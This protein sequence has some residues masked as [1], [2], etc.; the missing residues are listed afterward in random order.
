VVERYH[1][2]ALSIVWPAGAGTGFA[3]CGLCGV[4][5]GSADVSRQRYRVSSVD[6]AERQA[7][8]TVYRLRVRPHDKT[9][10]EYTLLVA[11]PAGRE[12]APHD[13]GQLLELDERLL[14][15]E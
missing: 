9:A 15:R 12:G 1:R 6:V 10:P 14:M 5:G 13:V 2:A 7:T 8:E 3:A 4:H 11:Q